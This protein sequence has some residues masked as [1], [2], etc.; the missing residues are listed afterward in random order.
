MQVAAQPLLGEVGGK[1]ARYGIDT[2]HELR[3][4][5][6]IF[7]VQMLV[8]IGIRFKQKTCKV[9][10]NCVDATTVSTKVQCWYV[11]SLGSHTFRSG[12]T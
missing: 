4:G 8:A 1:G 5:N 7:P 9:D 2:C 11:P 12:A 6:N 3:K 10:T